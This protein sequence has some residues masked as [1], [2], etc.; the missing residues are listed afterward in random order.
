MLTRAAVRVTPSTLA[1][2]PLEDIAASLG[3]MASDVNG[4]PAVRRRAA[5]ALEALQVERANAVCAA[6]AALASA[7]GELED[8]PGRYGTVRDP[9][10]GV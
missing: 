2:R 8:G 10:R 5:K 9:R 7:S 4:K 1:A 3:R 6:I